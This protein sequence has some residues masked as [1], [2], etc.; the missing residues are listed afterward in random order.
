MF[1]KLKRLTPEK[2]KKLIIGHLVGIVGLLTSGLIVFYFGPI[3]HEWSKSVEFF[4]LLAAIF[5]I[6]IK[7]MT[8]A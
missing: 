5:K 2:K 7:E 3:F 8:I 6:I 4:N 1:E